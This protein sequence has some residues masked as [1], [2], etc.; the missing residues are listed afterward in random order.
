MPLSSFFL[1]CL[2]MGI[3]GLIIPLAVELLACRIRPKKLSEFLLPAAA[4]LTTAGL[5]MTVWLQSPF[6]V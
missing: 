5:C 6:A 2:S 4:S 3:T 1:S